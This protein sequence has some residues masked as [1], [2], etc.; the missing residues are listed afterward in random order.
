MGVVHNVG[1]NMSSW[2]QPKSERYHQQK[3][4]QW[5]YSFFD[6]FALSQPSLLFINFIFILIV[7]NLLLVK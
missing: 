2:R 4:L 1:L 5:K 7:V 3:G 6:F